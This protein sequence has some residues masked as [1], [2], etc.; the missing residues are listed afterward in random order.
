MNQEKFTK[1]LLEGLQEI[2]TKADWLTKM[3]NVDTFYYVYYGWRLPF[4][5]NIDFTEEKYENYTEEMDDVY[6]M[7]VDERG[8]YMVFGKEIARA[9]DEM[10]VFSEKIDLPNIDDDDIKEKYK[11]LFGKDCK[12][13]P[14][15]L[16]FSHHYGV[17][18]AFKK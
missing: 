4:D 13:T 14:Y 9:Y 5:E 6:S 2:I 1:N 16:F 7:V 17:N 11:E 12:E 15:L 8:V 10:P 18:N 3:D